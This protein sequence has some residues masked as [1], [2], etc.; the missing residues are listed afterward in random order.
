M[1][2]GK[3]RNNLSPVAA[4]SGTDQEGTQAFLRVFLRIYRSVRALLQGQITKMAAQYARSKDETVK[5]EPDRLSAELAKLPSEVGV[6]CQKNREPISLA[7]AL[8]GLSLMYH[9]LR[10]LC[11]KVRGL[12][13]KVGRLIMQHNWAGKSLRPRPNLRHAGGLIAMTIQ[14]RRTTGLKRLG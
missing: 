5:A 3:V 1:A 10:K 12:G 2:G 6:L 4:R 7:L 8:I 11:V 13:L 14:F 9:V